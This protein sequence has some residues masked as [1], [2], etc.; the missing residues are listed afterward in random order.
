MLPDPDRRIER[1][2]AAGLQVTAPRTRCAASR[3][4][5]PTS[6]SYLEQI[7]G[8]IYASSSHASERPLDAGYRRGAASAWTGAHASGHLPAAR[9]RARTA[10][11]Y[12]ARDVRSALAVGPSRGESGRVVGRDGHDRGCPRWGRHTKG[13]P[14]HRLRRPLHHQLHGGEREDHGFRHRLRSHDLLWSPPDSTR[15]SF[16]FPS[17]KA[18]HG[19][20]SDSKTLHD[21]SGLDPHFTITGRFSSPTRAA[22]TLHEHIPVPANFGAPSCTLSQPFSVTLVRK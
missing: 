1:P 12:D 16:K 8:P 13:W 15:S 14:L 22:G 7:P 20:F 9:T 6:K 18:H 5:R 4:T 17:V 10:E 11:R 3:P 2:Q 21:R 19:R